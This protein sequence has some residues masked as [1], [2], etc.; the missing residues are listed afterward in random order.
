MRENGIITFKGVPYGVAERW[1]EADSPPESSENILGDAYGD[2]P[3]QNPNVEA[4]GG[5]SD[6]VAVGG[7]S[8]GSNGNIYAAP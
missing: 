4:F 7:Q 3:N 8:A 6:D 5:N 1:Q 2:I